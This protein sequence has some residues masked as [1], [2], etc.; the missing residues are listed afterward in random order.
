MATTRGLRAFV[1]TREFVLHRAT[2]LEAI[3]KAT[4]MAPR[5]KSGLLWAYPGGTFKVATHQQLCD[6]AKSK[7]LDVKIMDM[8]AESYKPIY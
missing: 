6:W 5:D 3:A 8:G 1:G 7:N 2:P 4:G